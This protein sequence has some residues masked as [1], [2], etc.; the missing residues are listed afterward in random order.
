[1]LLAGI[2]VL[3]EKMKQG[4][5]LLAVAVLLG[6]LAYL[7]GGGAT[8]SLPD[9]AG[10]VPSEESGSSVNPDSL[11]SDATPT[12]G[13]F[14]ISVHS[15]EELEVLFD[16]AEEH[17]RRP[18]PLGG[19]ESIVLV[20]HGP[21]VEFFAISN[22]DSYRAIV[23]RAARLDAFHVVDVKI[24]QTMMKNYGIEADDIPA[25]IEQVPNGAAEVERLTREGYVYF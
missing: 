13:V 18:K 14:D 23:D 19:E 11:H 4:M 24:C 16:R 22:Y 8:K 15:V 7:Y 3:G 21:E 12:R 1:M 9:D 17:A 25:F 5:A 20:L 2:Q 10:T 6:L